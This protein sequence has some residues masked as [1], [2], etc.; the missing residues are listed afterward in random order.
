M[1]HMIHSN[2]TQI[3]IDPISFRGIN[4]TSAEIFIGKYV[5]DFNIKFGV[6]SQQLS[7]GEI[8]Q[9]GIQMVSCMYQKDQKPLIPPKNFH[10]AKGIAER[11]GEL[12]LKWDP[13]DCNSPDLESGYVLSYTLYFCQVTDESSCNLNYNIVDSI[14]VKQDMQNYTIRKLKPGGR[15]KVWLT[16]RTSAGEGPPTDAIDTYIYMQEFPLWG[17]VIIGVGSLIASLVI[18]ICF[19][20]FQQYLKERRTAFSMI[21]IPVPIGHMH[22]QNGHVIVDG[23]SDGPI[24]DM[25][26]SEELSRI[27]PLIP[28]G[29][30]QVG[31]TKNSSSSSLLLEIW[32]SDQIQRLLDTPFFGID[33]YDSCIS[34]ND[35]NSASSNTESDRD[36]K[37]EKE[38]KLA[39]F[40]LSRELSHQIANRLPEGYCRVVSNGDYVPNGKTNPVLY[41]DKLDHKFLKLQGQ[42]VHSQ[43]IDSLLNDGPELQGLNLMLQED[44]KGNSCE[45]YKGVDS[46]C[47]KDS[48][49]LPQENVT[50]EKQI[51]LGLMKSKDNSELDELAVSCALNGSLSLLDETCGSPHKKEKT[52]GYV[53][54]NKVVDDFG[55]PFLSSTYLRHA[56][57]THPD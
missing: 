52:S 46:V 24:P 57:Y 14:P 21:E 44:C 53:P 8:T 35:M 22:Q 51:E 1:R 4:G 48:S 37:D 18:L 25:D 3:R 56:D 28:N 19:V 15:Y 6:E 30:A 41:E 33:H 17:K 55:K 45:R 11:E 49:K 20:K 43:S 27:I 39:D 36:I 47:E 29:N 23:Q 54:A 2:Q 31:M 38:I 26:E 7:M 50:I 40:V 16:A 42:T 32:Q 5:M 12:S 10:I 34:S 13:Y 9:S